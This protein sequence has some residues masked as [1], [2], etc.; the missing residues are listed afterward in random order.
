MRFIWLLSILI[1]VT[2]TAQDSLKTTLLDAVVVTGQFEPQSIRKSVYQVRTISHDRIVLRS[3]VNVQS[4]LSTEL[5]IRFSNDLTLGTSDISLMGMGG[6]NVKILLDGVPLLDRGA[7]RESLN[8]IDVNTIERIEIVEGPMSVM[9]GTDALAGVINIIT[10]K[11]DGEKWS[12]AAKIHEETINTEY[13]P[14]AGAGVHNENVSVNWNGK[15]FNA[16]GGITRNIFGGWQDGR[17]ADPSE[18]SIWHPKDQ[19]LGNATVGIKNNAAN[20]WY[21]L[22]YLDETITSDGRP[23]PNTNVA[24]DKEYLTDRF[25]HQLQADW[26][27]NG[28]LNFNGIASYQDYTRRTRTTTFNATTGERKLSPDAGSQAEAIFTTANVRGVFYYKLSDRVSFQPGVDVNL[29][30]GSGDRIDRTRRIDDYAVFVSSEIKPTSSI[31]IRP[32]LRFIHNS[33]YDAPPVVPSLNTKFSLTKSLDLRLA[34]GYG[35]RSPALRELYFYFFDA[36]HSIQGNPNLKAEH[37]NSFSASLTWQRT[38]SAGFRMNSTLGGFY[39]AFENLIDIGIDE[40]NPQVNTYINVYR[41]RTT[42]GTFEH[43]LGWR[44][45]NSTIGFSYIGTYNQFSED[46]TELPTLIWTPEFN[47]TV[48]WRIEKLGASA[49]LYYKYTG[50]RSNYEVASVDG[51]VVTRLASR[52]AFHFADLS[53]SK[54]ITSNVDLSAGIKNLFDLTDVRNS[55]MNAGNAHGGGTMVSMSYGR[56]YFLS[57]NFHLT[58]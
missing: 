55:T 13:K 3:P 47:S 40:A 22:N 11:F 37:S 18:T 23:N 49:S 27:I 36:S 25:N 38:T 56:S 5:G 10:K 32:G 26:Q 53:L 21:R 24:T 30:E 35:F 2:A 52:D 20:I 19:W 42:G 7:T 46:D 29:N 34:Y 54:K 16:G 1:S 17:I 48:T 28:R 6:Q 14:F 41:F 58:K 9:Y 8:Q 33:V 50:K 45:L 57:L 51:E 15:L 39:N 31:N 44:S 4:I 12:I 43:N